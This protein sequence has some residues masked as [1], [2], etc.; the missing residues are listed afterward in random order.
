MY[1]KENDLNNLIGIKSTLHREVVANNTYLI[2]KVFQ[3]FITSTLEKFKQDFIIN[4]D[5]NTKLIFLMKEIGVLG[6]FEELL[7]DY[8]KNEFEMKTMECNVIHDKQI[9]QHII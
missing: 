6:L 1:K 8:I 9:L 4:L 7:E 5:L 3:L 2:T